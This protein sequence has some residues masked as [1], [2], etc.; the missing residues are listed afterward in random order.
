MELASFSILF[1]S[2]A[3]C[4]PLALLSHSKTWPCC[5]NR[6]L[7][8]VVEIL[9]I[10]S[11]LTNHQFMVSLEPATPVGCLV[12]T[13]ATKHTLETSWKGQNEL[14]K[15]ATSQLFVSNSVWLVWSGSPRKSQK[16]GFGN[17]TRRVPKFRL[18]FG[19]AGRG[20]CCSAVS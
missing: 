8:L 10:L 7:G 5:F 20:R 4:L 19:F 6:R 2:G 11:V 14:I 3:A 12:L 13:P 17:Q 15:S 1:V 16:S 9:F 18:Q